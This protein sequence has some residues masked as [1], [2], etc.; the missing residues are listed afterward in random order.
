M[1]E[2]K[3]PSL[4]KRMKTVRAKVDRSKIYPSTTR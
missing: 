2:Q 3:T 4:T 1:A